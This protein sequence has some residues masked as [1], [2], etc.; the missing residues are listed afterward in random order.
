MGRSAKQSRP[1]TKLHDHIR[2]LGMRLFTSAVAMIIV[3][4]GVYAFYGPILDLLRSPLGAPLYYSSP[5]GSFAFVMKICFVGA[6]TITIPVLV[7]N[8]I[9]FVRP[10]FSQALSTKR[11]Y[12]TSF[13]S[14]LLAIA[15][16]AFAFYVI[17]PESLKFFAGFQVTGLNALISADSYLGFVTNI[18]VTF[19]IVFQLPLLIAFI[20]H[21]KPLK[22]SKLIGFEKW[23]I[24][25]SLII[26]LLAPFT[27]DLITSLLI[28]LPIVVLYNLSIVMVVT[29]HAMD[30]RRARRAIHST[31]VKPVLTPEIAV[32]ELVFEQIADEL[33]NFKKPMVAPPVMI[34]VTTPV[35]AP[36]ATPIINP[37]PA[38]YGYVKRIKPEPIQPPAW[39]IERKMR[40][41]ALLAQAKA[42]SSVHQ[43]ACVKRVATA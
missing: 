13:I 33:I 17:L 26:A 39:A 42:F 4:V 30:A 29:K 1:A 32:N 21:I 20:D 10:A 24:L 19:V 27:Y 34:A 43:S 28:A 22:P 14:S 16:A 40:R 9:M 12:T 15:G 25:G 2:E 3:G 6:L 37:A 41:E 23:V 38:N 7:Y 35:V 8:L 18:I 36:V 11:V 5:A 31:V